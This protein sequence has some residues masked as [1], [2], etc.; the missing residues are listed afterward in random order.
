MGTEH[1]QIACCVAPLGCPCRRRLQWVAPKWRCGQKRSG[2]SHAVEQFCRDVHALDAVA[3][4]RVPDH[5]QG[6]R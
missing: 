3:A 6:Q 1:D 5:L 2:V 4:A